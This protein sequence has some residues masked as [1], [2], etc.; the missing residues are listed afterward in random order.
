MLGV[1]TKLPYN[2]F[3]VDNSTVVER[4]GLFLTPE[5]LILTT[6]HCSTFNLN[7]RAMEHAKNMVG[8]NVDR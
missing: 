6:F 2:V 8:G 7:H 5:P 4:Q 1:D 3:M